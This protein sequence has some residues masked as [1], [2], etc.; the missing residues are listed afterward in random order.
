MSATRYGV[1]CVRMALNPTFGSKN[2][3]IERDY[4]WRAG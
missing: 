4:D 1:I 3:K 2:Q